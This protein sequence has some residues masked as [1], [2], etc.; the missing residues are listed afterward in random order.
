MVSE[1]VKQRQIL[2]KVNG[3]HEHNVKTALE[4]SFIAKPELVEPDTTANE[5]V[6]EKTFLGYR[7]SN[8]E[9]GIRNEV[10]VIPTVGCVNATARNIAK[11][12]S[13]ELPDGVD[14]CYAFEHHTAAHSLVATMS[15]PRRYLLVL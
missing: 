6:A 12:A 4:G 13:T 1:L 14:G 2:Q 15:V 10:W 8:G 11:G 5:W 7:R 9:I 3:V